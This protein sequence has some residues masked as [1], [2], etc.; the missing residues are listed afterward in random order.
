M[1]KNRISILI[2]SLLIITIG[3]SYAYGAL[4]QGSEAPSFTLMDLK[5]NAVSLEGLRG[6]KMI[7]LY[8]FT[9]DSRP[10]REGLIQLKE[11]YDRYGKEGIEVIGISR[12]DT[13]KLKEFYESNKIG[14]SMLNDS[15]NVSDFYNARAILPTTYI[16]SPQGKITDILQGGGASTQQLLN[17]IAERE[18]ERKKDLTVARNIYKRA[19]KNNPKDIKA[20]SGIGYS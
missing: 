16:I 15:K 14:F 9:I 17:S 3:G 8:F 2:A 5:S 13:V 10:C 12:D 6:K 7:V 11:I 20:K 1:F 19:L 18:F 4:T